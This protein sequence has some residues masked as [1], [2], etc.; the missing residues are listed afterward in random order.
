MKIEFFKHKKQ[1]CY[2]AQNGGKYLL[3]SYDSLIAVIDEKGNLFFGLDWDYST[4]TSKHLNHFL[5]SYFMGKIPL[6]KQ[7]KQK[8]I[9]AGNI[10]VLCP[11]SLEKIFCGDFQ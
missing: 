11:D 10:T 5:Q 2:I 6:T 3:K 8:E 9:K 4:T 1:N 7:E